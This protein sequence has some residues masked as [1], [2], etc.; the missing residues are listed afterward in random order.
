MEGFEGL[1]EQAPG[2]AAVIVM[3][4]LFLKDRKGLQDIHYKTIN[5]LFQESDNTNKE[6][7]VQLKETTVVLGRSM[8]VNEQVA[9]V[10]EKVNRSLEKKDS[11]TRIDSESVKRALKEIELQ[12][13]NA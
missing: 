8:Q 12:R 9:T 1:V 3:A 4:F 13:S 2:A 6:L 11:D 10:L 5:T 7:L